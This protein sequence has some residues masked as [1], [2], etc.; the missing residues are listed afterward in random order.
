M[1]KR[2]SWYKVTCGVGY[3]RWTVTM[4]ADTCDAAWALA[5]RRGAKHDLE[6]HNVEWHSYVA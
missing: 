1:V 4:W 2:K 3:H 6:I 5:V